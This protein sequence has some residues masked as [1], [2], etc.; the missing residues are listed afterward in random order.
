MNENDL[1][2]EPARAA[3]VE[4]KERRSRFIASLDVAKS[5]DEAREFIRATSQNHAEANHN[6]WAYR[7]GSSGTV[8][9]FSDAGEPSGTA[10]KPILGAILRADV[11]NA[12]VIVTRYFGGTKLGVR[13]LI[14]AYG[15]CAS[16]A[17][18]AAGRKRRVRSRKAF[19]ECSYEYA[20]AIIRQLMEIGIPEEGIAPE[21][22]SCV[23]L[24]VEVPL[25]LAGGAEPFFE[26]YA[27]RGF[28]TCW[29]WGK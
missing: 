22:G 25:A 17:L 11:V 13:G 7:V 16:L 5:E 26:G 15:K 9:Y 10:G 6:C 28:I 1:V 4:I 3:V 18:D 8:E 29:G 24:V 20:Q 23:R 27:E 21:W 2:T 14:E 12:V 19:V